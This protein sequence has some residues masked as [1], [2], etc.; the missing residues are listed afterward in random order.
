MSS[1]SLKGRRKREVGRL[2][3]AAHSGGGGPV[4]KSSNVPGKDPFKL[5][6][7]TKCLG[8]AKGLGT[9]WYTIPS[10]AIHNKTSSLPIV[11]ISAP[12]SLFSAVLR[13]NVV[14]TYASTRS[15]SRFLNRSSGSHSST[16]SLTK[17]PIRIQCNALQPYIVGV[18]RS[19]QRWQSIVHVVNLISDTYSGPAVYGPRSGLLVIADL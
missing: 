4:S 5:A 6:G 10:Q 8:V 19:N 13:W 16:R 3:G 1:R 7:G 11:S 12:Y 18:P 14:Y 15:E 2:I 17:V 9:F